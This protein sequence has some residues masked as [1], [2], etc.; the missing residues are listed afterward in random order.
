MG[1]STCAKCNDASKLPLNQCKV[2]K[3]W[4]RCNPLWSR[5]VLCKYHKNS[6][7]PCSELGCTKNTNPSFRYCFYHY[8]HYNA[9]DE[10]HIESCTTHNCKGFVLM[11]K[12]MWNPKCSECR[13][14]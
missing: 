8:V 6:V 10:R 7:L 14:N 11:K 2:C 4:I 1:S 3:L 12:D 5:N 13:K 9:N